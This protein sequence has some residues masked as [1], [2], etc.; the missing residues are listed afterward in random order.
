[1]EILKIGSTGTKV[2]EIQSLLNKLGYN[3]GDIDGI[4][5]TRTMQAVSRFQ[6]YFGL[7]ATGIVDDATYKLMNRFLLGMILIELD[8]VTLFIL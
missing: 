7:P 2:M 6:R 4:Y 5:G 8:R 1:L 3:P